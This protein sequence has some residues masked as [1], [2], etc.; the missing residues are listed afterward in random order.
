MAG[1]GTADLAAALPDPNIAPEQVAAVEPTADA[2]AVE[3]KNPQVSS[4]DSLNIP[5]G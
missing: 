5:P 4:E 2:S 3:K 1:W